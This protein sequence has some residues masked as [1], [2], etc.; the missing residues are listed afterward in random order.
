[1]LRSA[2]S[3]NVFITIESA[4]GS[5]TAA[6]KPLQPAHRDQEPVAVRKPR[7]Q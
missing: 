2:P 4:A 5:T 7:A 1:L 3:L 6:P